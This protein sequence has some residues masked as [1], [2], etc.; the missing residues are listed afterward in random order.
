MWEL[1]QPPGPSP[2][3]TVLISS[4][5][6][7][8]RLTDR[9]FANFFNL[10]VTAGNET[11]RNAIS[12]GAELHMRRVAT[13]AT[14]LDGQEISAGDKVVMWYWSANRDESEF[15]NGAYLAIIVVVAT[16]T[17]VRRD[18]AAAT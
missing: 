1:P 3:H 7:G 5:V 4:E 12:W 13:E 6:D 17:F 9:E 14:V 11:T 10:L 15:P 16:S 18:A 8:Q 2:R